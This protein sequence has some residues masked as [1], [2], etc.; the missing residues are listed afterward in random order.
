MKKILLAGA[1]AGAIALAGCQTTDLTSTVSSIEAQV[2][3]DSNL[4]C[5]FIPTAASIASVIANLAAPGSGA[6][7]PDAATIAN[8]ICSAIANAP[9]PT[10]QSARLRSLRMGG[11]L[12]TPVTVGNLRLPGGSVVPITGSFTR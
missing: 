2:Q 7:V 1:M 6:L 3:S 9:K 10:V 4:F 8:S 5:S 11:A 12:G